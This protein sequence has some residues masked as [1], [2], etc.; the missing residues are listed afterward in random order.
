MHYHFQNVRWHCLNFNWCLLYSYN[1]RNSLLPKHIWWWRLEIF[2]WI[3]FS[4]SKKV[5]KLLKSIWESLMVFI[6]LVALHLHVMLNLL[7]QW[8]LMCIGGAQTTLFFFYILS[9]GMRH[10]YT[11]IIFYVQFVA[12]VSFKGFFLSLSTMNSCFFI[13]LFYISLFLVELPFYPFLF[14]E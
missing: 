12:S 5:P 10:K 7:F 13:Q 3:W 9:A 1:E 6:M 2:K 4:K 8:P 14:F 11:I